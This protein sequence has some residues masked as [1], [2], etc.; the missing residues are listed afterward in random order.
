MDGLVSCS[1]NIYVCMYVYIT[2]MHIT[3]YMQIRRYIYTYTY[4]YITG[5]IYSYYY[6]PDIHFI[7]YVVYGMY[8]RTCLQL[9]I[10]PTMLRSPSGHVKTTSGW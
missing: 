7:L 2:Q 5:D 3:Q 6:T 4:T 1:W 10:A 8:V 9:H